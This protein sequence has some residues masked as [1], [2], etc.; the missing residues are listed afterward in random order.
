M[1]NCNRL[2]ALGRITVAYDGPCF[3][4]NCDGDEANYICGTDSKT[5]RNQCEMRKT[6]CLEKRQINI[7]FF[8]R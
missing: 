5:Y 4:Q 8:G 2:R 7:K 1:A 3:D 6:A